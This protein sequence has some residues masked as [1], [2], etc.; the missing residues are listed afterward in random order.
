MYSLS[1]NVSEYFGYLFPLFYLLVRNFPGE[2]QICSKF[3][4]SGAMKLGNQQQVGTHGR[5]MT[6]AEVNTKVTQEILR[7]HFVKWIL[8]TYIKIVKL[9]VTKIQGS[10]CSQG[11]GWRAGGIHCLYLSV[12]FLPSFVFFSDGMVELFLHPRSCSG[13]IGWLTFVCS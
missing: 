7:S 8:T 3:K 9:T 12:G 13:R 2:V 4:Y 11:E 5:K 1:C 10:G 6:H